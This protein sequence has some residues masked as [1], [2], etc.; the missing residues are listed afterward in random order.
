MES[1]AQ[2]RAEKEAPPPGIRV[3]A[4]HV[5]LDFPVDSASKYP[6]CPQHALTVLLASESALFS[7]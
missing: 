6:T 2:P 3:A 1:K 7:R 5:D 4:T